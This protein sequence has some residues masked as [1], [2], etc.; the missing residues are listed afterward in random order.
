MLTATP[1]REFAGGRTGRGYGAVYRDG[2]QVRVHRLI[3]EQAG[4]DQYGTTWSP[5][6]DVLHECDNPPCF[7]YDHL[8]L[9]THDDNMADRRSKGRDALSGIRDTINHRALSDDDVRAIRARYDAGEPIASIAA[10]YPITPGA[11]GRVCR[12]QTW[13]GI[14]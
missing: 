4:E 11:T 10:D 14:A 13:K 6:L 1:C 12:R 5:E 8:F 3:V 9:G 2:K 7:R